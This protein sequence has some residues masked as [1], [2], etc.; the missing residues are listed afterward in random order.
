MDCTTSTLLIYD[1]LII[2]IRDGSFLQNQEYRLG[3][4]SESGYVTPMGMM[5]ITV[6]TREIE[7]SIVHGKGRMRLS[8]DV[9][10][11]GLFTH[12][13]E[14]IVDVREDPE[15]SWKSEKN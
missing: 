10:L 1:D 11:E 8:Y 6:V 14:I 9:E 7:N 12:L 5:K 4:K 3:E 15:Y 13:N 2:L